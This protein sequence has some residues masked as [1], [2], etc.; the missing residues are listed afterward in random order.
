[1]ETEEEPF[2]ILTR[3]PEVAEGSATMLVPSPERDMF[4]PNVSGAFVTV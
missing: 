3:L 4:D 2:V 1:M